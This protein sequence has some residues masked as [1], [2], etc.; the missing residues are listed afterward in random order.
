MDTS[1]E[2]WAASAWGTHA[3]L[4]PEQLAA[5]RQAGVDSLHAQLLANRGIGTPGEMKRFI[6]ARLD[7]VPDPLALIDM[8]RAVERLER[9]LDRGERIAIV[10]DFDADGVTA[11]ALLTRVL[12]S[13]GHPPDRLEC[14]IPHRVYDPRGLSREGLDVISAVWDSTLVLTADC[15]SSDAEAVE[16]ARG[17]GI[18]VVI[19][20]HH[21]PQAELPQVCAMVNPWRADSAPGER[22]LCGVGIAFKLALAL[23]RAHDCS[24]EAQTYL[25]LVALGTIADVASLLGEN[26]TL[27]R[28]GLEQLNRT[29]NRGLRS[30]VQSARLVPGT[31]RERD[32]SYAL[33]PRINAAG[34]MK[35]AYLAYRL[36]VTDDEVE[37][38]AIAREIEAL[39]LLR[40]Q[41]TDAV[42]ALAREQ[43]QAQ[44]GEPVVLVGGP[45]ADWPPGII[46][47][48]AGR[49]AEECARP[50]FV[51]SAGEG[52]SRGSARSGGGFNLIE[53]LAERPDLFEAYGGHAQAAGFTIA[54]A[55]VPELHSHLRTWAARGHRERGPRL[56][57]I[58]VGH[59]GDLRPEVYGA[60]RQLAPFGAGNP[61]PVL[62]MNGVTLSR[63][64]LGGWD[65]G[66][67]RVRLE[68]QGVRLDGMLAG[69]GAL[70]DSLAEGALVDVVFSL[71]LLPRAAGGGSQPGIWLKVLAIEPATNLADEAMKEDL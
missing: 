4:P 28:L 54:S 31:I 19:T 46:G 32:V 44:S 57:D 6:D 63:R 1:I 39:N 35:D 37:A 26:H 48:V 59:P 40:R 65:G 47:L 52:S 13:L 27:A 17:L 3:A 2:R 21:Q 38:E 22:C 70:L 25:D 61:E 24:A 58:V 51:L 30:L 23:L 56:V 29:E 16:Y 42:L 62:R 34:R 41:L 66:S 15:G 60:L 14:T 18:D 43:A 36:L 67:L 33:G 55:R 11:A 50:T 45:S 9:A 12:L 49:L 20:D 10:G 8:S 69:G 71:D 5:C 53:A 7:E 68:A 64:W